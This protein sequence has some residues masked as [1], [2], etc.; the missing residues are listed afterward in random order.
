MT[1]EE[2]LNTYVAAL[3]APNSAERRR[4]LT[5]CFTA[6]GTQ[7][8]AQ[9]SLHA[10]DAI[11]GHIDDYQAANPGTRCTLSKDYRTSPHHPFVWSSIRVALADGRTL[12]QTPIIELDA[13]NRIRRVVMFWGAPPADFD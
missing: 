12:I 6:D 5:A 7:A 2:T 11:A 8:G 13:D 10:V 1:V 4:L 9:M 3:N